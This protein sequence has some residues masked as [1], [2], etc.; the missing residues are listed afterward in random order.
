MNLKLKELRLIKGFS[1][2]EIADYLHCTAVTYSRYENG[3]R[4]PSPDLL[5]KLADYFDVTVDYLLGRE[6]I[7]EN[8]LTQYEINLVN[9]SRKTDKRAKEDALHLLLSHIDDV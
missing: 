4:S 7:S 1:Q 5:V 9:A 3:N 2:Q 8:G 6:N